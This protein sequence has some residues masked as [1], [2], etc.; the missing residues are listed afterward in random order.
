MWDQEK[1]YI[2]CATNKKV[3]SIDIGVKQIPEE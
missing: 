3:G 1:G 2:L